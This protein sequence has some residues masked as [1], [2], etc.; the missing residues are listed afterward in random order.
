[1][2]PQLICDQ[3]VTD[4]MDGLDVEHARAYRNANRQV[5]RCIATMSCAIA[6]RGLSRYLRRIR[7]RKSNYC[8]RAAHERIRT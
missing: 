6:T 2:A 7:A 4:R 3:F 8:F 5:L 1:M